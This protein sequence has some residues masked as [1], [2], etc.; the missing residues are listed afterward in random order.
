MK[1]AN[2]Q[3]WV[4]FASGVVA[5][6]CAM[7]VLVGGVGFAA[8]R[9][10]DL[11]HFASVLDLVRRNYVEPVDEHEL[12]EGAL[13]GL[14][15]SL[16]P[17]SAYMSSEAYEEMQVD[18]SGEFHGLGIEITKGPGRYVLVVSPIEGTPAFRAGI[19][20]KDQITEICPTEVPED[21]E[22]GETCR[23]TQAMT[24]IEAVSLMR[25][26]K[27]TE[28]TIHVYREGFEEPRPFTIKRDVVQMASVTTKTLEPGFGHLRIRSFQERTAGEVSD[29]L[30]AL[31]V[32]NPD[33]LEGLVLDL[34]DNPGGLLT[35]AVSVADHWLGDGLIVYTQG[36]N[37]DERQDFVARIEGTEPDYPI[38]VLVNAGSASAS[39]I[40]AGAL[41][42]QDRALVLGHPTFGKGSVQTVFPLE[43]GAALRLTTALYYTPSGR[44]IQEVGID[45]D[46]ALSVL[47]A[48]SEERRSR[49]RERDLLGHLTHAQADPEDVPVAS[50][51][52]AT[53]S[54]EGAVPG[55]VDDATDE[56]TDPDAAAAS[57]P[58]A[59]DE[60]DLVLARAVEVLKSWRY[61]EGLRARRLPTVRASAE[62]VSDEGA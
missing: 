62:P 23:N 49:M 10:Q 12:M 3:S 9:Y 20:A 19:E 24:L 48:V 5:T 54:T 6:L 59:D 60:R 22:E 1:R 30:A 32:E 25:G 39:E 35:Q 34:R 31:H 7:A 27:G 16:D 40:V 17:H 15:S 38:V 56:V 46:I 52:G 57:D 8:S 47:A 28:I 14:L 21:W 26:R 18:T 50:K 2:R 53:N 58:A 55:A 11:S 45:P 29:G 41:Q 42:D 51:D 37:D 61:F 43:D 13:Q 36:R 33:G 44:S 4:A